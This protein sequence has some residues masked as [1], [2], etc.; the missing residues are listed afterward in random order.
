MQPKRVIFVCVLLAS[1][2]GGAPAGAQQPLE[3][4]RDIR[5][6]LSDRCF[7]CHGPNQ[8]DRQGEL[9][10]DQADGPEGAHHAAIKPGA[11]EESELWKRITSS[12]PDLMMPPADSKKRP[13]TDKEQQLIRQWIEQ[14]G[15]YRQFWAFVT[16]VMPKQPADF[17]GAPIDRFVRRRLQEEG[18]DPAPAADKRTLIRRLSFDLTGL[19]PSRTEI[20]QFLAADS[21]RAYEKLV[22]RLLASPHHGEHMAKYWLDLVRF[23][24]TNGIHHDHYRE[25]SPY[26]DWVIRAFS[27]NLPFDD[28]VRYQ[29]AGDLYPEPS[30][31]Q[32]T[33]SGFHRLHLIIDRGTALPE[34][35]F[36]R[37]VI[38]RVISVGTA[39][40]GMTVQCAMCHDHKYD[41]MTMK[42]LYSL[43]AFFNNIDAAPE[44]GGRRGTDFQRGLQPPYVNLSDQQQ[45]AELARLNGEVASAEAA[46][47]AHRAE[48]A[49][50]PK[51]GD[52]KQQAE[53]AAK[54]A[55]QKLDK[56][57]QAR[58]NYLITIPA[59]MVMKERAD[60]RPAF[61]LLRGAYDKQGQQ[62]GRTTPAFL[63]PLGVDEDNAT[64]MDLADWFV[65]REHP[66][67]ARVTVN[68]FW[69]QLFGVGIVRTSEDFGAQGEWP[70]HPDLLD[71][72]SVRFV[73]GGWNVREL[74]KEI[75]MSETYRQSSHAAPE[76]YKGDPNSRLLARGSRYCMDAE[77]I[78]DQVLASSGLLNRTMFGKSVKPPQPDGLW[79]AV[80]MPS[81]YPSQF[82]A[83]SGEKIYRRSLYTFWK[84]GMPPPQMTILN[85]PTR[86]ECTARRERTNTPLQALLLL[87]E[88]EYL[89]A[90]RSLAASVLQDSSDKPADSVDA[91]YETITSQLPGKSERETLLKLVADLQSL[92]Q[93]SPELAEELCADQPLP[94]GVSRPQWAAWTMLASSIYNL[95]ITKNRQ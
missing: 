54:Q 87:N 74:L 49:G 30:R 35:S 52:Q 34:E 73:D 88:T 7:H 77:M 20:R 58:D 17:D 1:C 83:D 28:F 72:L 85:A 14:G 23:A 82:E 53:A 62:V 67:T 93:Q 13:L 65:S 44:T 38:D 95:D 90:A 22:D 5:S 47:A 63:P 80:S 15:Q 50:A 84:R 29:L 79:T 64:R 55:E 75:V 37:N 69:Q 68:R 27:D 91:I 66:L 25:L 94:A 42:D 33:A 18:L 6:L 26:R 46:L 12:D 60:K 2:I 43:S 39:F 71:Y 70:S 51:N 48:A 40:M 19:P 81:S 59:A 92:Y 41:P 57:R 21:D 31:D 11:P 16:P 45:A 36:H 76:A 86:E 89:K 4:N 24:D 61:V 3:Y 56:V 9:R 10:L 78:R 8:E 32:L